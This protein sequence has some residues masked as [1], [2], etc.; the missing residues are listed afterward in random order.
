MRS[1]QVNQ[2][3]VRS[4]IRLVR[5]V[6]DTGIVKNKESIMLSFEMGVRQNVDKR[7]QKLILIPYRRH[8]VVHV[9][10][11]ALIEAD[12]GCGGA[13]SVHPAR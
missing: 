6:S 11:L 12:G 7:H 8:L 13:V 1:Y 4:T 9:E 5:P 10:Y 2:K 3:P